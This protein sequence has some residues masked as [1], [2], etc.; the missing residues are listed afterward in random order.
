MESLDLVM[1][2]GHT[3]ILFLPL[4]Y[5]GGQVFTDSCEMYA[6]AL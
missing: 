1:D 4:V 2:I 5:T 6:I 3:H